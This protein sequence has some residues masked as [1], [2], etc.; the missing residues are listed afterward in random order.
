ME[1]YL[2]LTDDIEAT[3]RFYC[4]ALDMTVGFRPELDFPGYW[5]YL[6]D[7][8]CIHV[9]DWRAYAKW[10]KRVGIPIS[11]RGPGTG[12]LDHIAFNASGYAETVERLEGLGI[13]MSC[14][15]LDDIGLKQLFIKDPNGLMIELNFRE[16]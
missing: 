12:P 14:N 10:T 15:E 2:V 7:T 13:G 3:R 11:P 4:D 5:I 9:G 1:H 16:R 6:G 8:P